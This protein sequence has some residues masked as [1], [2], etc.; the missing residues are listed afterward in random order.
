ML[1]NISNWCFLRK[2]RIIAYFM[3][4]LPGPLHKHL[5]MVCVCCQPNTLCRHV[6]PVP[7]TRGHW[8]T[9]QNLESKEWPL[10][11]S[12]VARVL[13]KVTPS[14]EERAPGRELPARVGSAPAGT[15]EEV[16]SVFQNVSQ[17]VPSAWD[18][19]ELGLQRPNTKS[20]H[21]IKSVCMRVCTCPSLSVCLCMCLGVHF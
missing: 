7:R 18:K 1:N 2:Q 12:S 16:C 21:S 14:L 8:R 15:S 17:T 9:G 3:L 19:E 5:E 10:G 20:A 4:N 13:E 6:G 11:G